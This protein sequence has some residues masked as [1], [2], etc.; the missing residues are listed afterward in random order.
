MTT[1]VEYTYIYTYIT[2]NFE[3][4]EILWPFQQEKNNKDEADEN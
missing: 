2:I 3:C 1:N 4:E